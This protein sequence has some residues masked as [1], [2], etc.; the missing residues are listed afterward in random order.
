ATRGAE[1]GILIEAERSGQVVFGLD[2]GYADA[3]SY[4]VA[5]HS[6]AGDLLWQ[7]GGLKPNEEQ[8]LSLT[9]PDALLP[10]GSY[11]FTVRP[12]GAGTEALRFPFEMADD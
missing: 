7:S 9:L 11:R 8:S 2:I 1:D 12:E 6:A 3:S 10:V 5:L 4:S